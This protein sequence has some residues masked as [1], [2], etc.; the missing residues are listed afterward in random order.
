MNKQEFNIATNF[1]W[2]PY[3]RASRWHSGKEY[4][5]NVGDAKDGGLIPGLE[6]FPGVRNGHPL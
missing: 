5:S 2:V 1:K 3:L 6:R 4:A